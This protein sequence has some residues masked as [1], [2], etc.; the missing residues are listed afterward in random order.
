MRAITIHRESSFI[1]LPGYTPDARVKRIKGEVGVTFEVLPDG[2]TQ[3]I[4]IV[5]SLDPGLDQAVVEAATHW[6]FQPGTK[7][8]T[9]VAVESSV[10]VTFHP[11]DVGI[12][13]AHG[14]PGIYHGLPCAQKIDSREIKD[15]LK[16]ANKGDA[17]SQFIL[18]C[19]REF[20]VDMLATDPAQAIEWYRKAA[21]RLVPAQYFLGYTYLSIFDYLHAYTWLKIAELNGYKDP[22]DWLRTVTQ[23]LSKDEMSA[24]E[25]QVAAWQREHALSQ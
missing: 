17:N 20:G 23:L 18:G 9:P 10:T 2:R 12:P 21:E 4:R 25:E 7:S 24:A 19:A 6:R 5:K 3:N 22:K 15:V 14:G 11:S 13:V 16:K 8:G 1:T